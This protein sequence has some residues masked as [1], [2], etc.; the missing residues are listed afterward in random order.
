MFLRNL[1]K[2][3]DIWIRRELQ[4]AS[5]FVLESHHNSQF[6]TIHIPLGR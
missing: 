1:K 3:P 2:E 5:Q 4:Q 6:E